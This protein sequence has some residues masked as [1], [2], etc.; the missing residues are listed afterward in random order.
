MAVVNLFNEACVQGPAVNLRPA[1]PHRSGLHFAALT[2][3][4]P[5]WVEVAASRVAMPSSLQQHVHG[6]D[7]HHA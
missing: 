1:P 3:A 4:S 6:L 2:P 7:F 5:R